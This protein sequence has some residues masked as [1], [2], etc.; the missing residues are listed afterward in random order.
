[1]KGQHKIRVLHKGREHLAALADVNMNSQTQGK[2]FGIN[3]CF[4]CWWGAVVLPKS[5]T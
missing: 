4:V 3:V 1:M 5:F 2:M